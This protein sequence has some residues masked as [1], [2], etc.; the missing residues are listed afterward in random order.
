MKKSLLAGVITLIAVAALGLAVLV[1]FVDGRGPGGE[2]RIE[3]VSENVG[4]A[5]VFAGV[6]AF[7]LVWRRQKR[8]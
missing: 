5:S 1:L 4:S 2:A 6:I 8:G 7:Y 3:R